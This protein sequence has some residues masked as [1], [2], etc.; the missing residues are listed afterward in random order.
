MT[1]AKTHSRNSPLRS[2]ILRLLELRSTEVRVVYELVEIGGGAPRRFGSPEAL[3]RF[4]AEG[5]AAQPG[6][7][8]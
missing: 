2:Y 1:R 5:D 6:D 8:P 3:R 4:L 7:R